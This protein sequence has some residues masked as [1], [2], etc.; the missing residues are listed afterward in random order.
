MIAMLR[1]YRK[2][3]SI[4]ITASKALSSQ[5]SKATH[6]NSLDMIR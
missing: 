5:V 1:A 4:L 3:Q 2:R 6:A